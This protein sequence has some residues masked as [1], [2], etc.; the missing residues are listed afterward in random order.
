MFNYI[1]L[2][3]S[4]AISIVIIC[5][6]VTIASSETGPV[7]M[8]TTYAKIG[9]TRTECSLD[10]L[11]IGNPGQKSVTFDRIEIKYERDSLVR[12]DVIVQNIY[13]I[14]DRRV[15]KNYM[16]GMSPEEMKIAEN[17]KFELQKIDGGMQLNISDVPIYGDRPSVRK[18]TAMTIK[19]YKGDVQVGQSYTANLPARSS[20]TIA[21]GS[22]PGTKGSQ[23]YKLQFNQN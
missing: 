17:D 15:V 18:A 11:S 14:K 8:A 6:Q 23:G 4:F 21:P 9:L 7:I 13:F 2:V 12:G 1:S 3:I 19:L 5:Q 16:H 10:P 20:L 22:I